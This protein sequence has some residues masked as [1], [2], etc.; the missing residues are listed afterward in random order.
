MLSI[1]GRTLRHIS[2]AANQPERQVGQRVVII[3]AGGAGLAAGRHLQ[4]AGYDVTLLEARDRIGGRAWTA[5]DLA[6]HPI[7]L[8]AEFVHGSTASSWQWLNRF[9]LKTLPTIKDRYV[10]AA[11]GNEIKKYDALIKEDWDD[12]IWELAEAWLAA[13][14]GDISLRALLDDAEM[15]LPYTSELA[16]L[17]NNTYAEDY[18]AD[19]HLLSAFGLLE[20]DYDGDNAE[21]G[22]Y[23]LVDGYT[24]LMDA[25]AENLDIRLQ[26]PITSVCYD[27]EG[28]HVTAEDGSVFDADY[29]IVTLP[30]AILQAGDV[31]FEPALPDEKCT[32]IQAIGSGNVNKV[33]LC[34]DQAFWKEKMSVLYTALDSQMW[35][36]PGWGRPDE[37][38]IL[39]AFAGGE[40]GSAHSTMSDDEAIAHSLRNL[41]TLFGKDVSSRL[42]WGRFINWGADPY[43]KMGYSYNGVRS[44]GARAVLAAPVINRLFFAGEACNTVRPATVHGAMETGV[45]AAKAI[46]DL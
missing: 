9:K 22:D 1:V 27:A 21:D 24:H 13:G 7:E 45:S 40:A 16:Q 20:A 11:L 32:A 33:I 10:Y 14:K 18:G 35:W 6:S 46:L 8:G 34:F 39:T 12:D 15:L 23:R 4:D 29:V 5:Y 25:L 31:H 42:Q 36:R 17:I 44:Q 19:L 38:P 26:T 43:S 2:V 3:G 30:L 37:A 28:V 41:S